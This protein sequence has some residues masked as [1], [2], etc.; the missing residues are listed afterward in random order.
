MG[1]CVSV[2]LVTISCV[3]VVVTAL[4]MAELSVIESATAAGERILERIK[5]LVI[6][7]HST[8]IENRLLGLLCGAGW[9]LVA[10][11]PMTAVRPD[12]LPL[13]TF[14]LGRIVSGPTDGI[15]VWVNPRL[16][17]V[18]VL[19]I[20]YIYLLLV[21]D[22]DPVVYSC[23]WRRGEGSLRQSGLCGS[24]ACEVKKWSAAAGT[25]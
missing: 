10:A 3:S 17:D 9:H 20:L 2:G 19:L 6:S 14:M 24:P 7:T 21:L 22:A 12:G 23:A 4:Q 15:Q 16:V 5:M 25:C 18:E 11:S 13:A 8:A 1:L